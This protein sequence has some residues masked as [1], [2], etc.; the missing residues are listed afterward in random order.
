M[1]AHRFN[2]GHH[3][4]M[5]MSINGVQVWAIHGLQ[6]MDLEIAAGCGGVDKEISNAILDV[7]VD[8]TIFVGQQPLGVHP[9][10]ERVCD[11]PAYRPPASS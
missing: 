9:V 8:R 4:I 2:E 10:I 11:R 5:L 1:T 6:I 3:T 7:R